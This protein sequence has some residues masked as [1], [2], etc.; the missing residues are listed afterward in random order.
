MN[1]GERGAKRLVVVLGMHRSG[2]SAAAR[3]LQ[4]LG[5]D[6]GDRLEPPD[7][8]VNAKGYFEDMDLV[9]L[10]D[11]MLAAVDRDWA[12]LVATTA[13]DVERLRRLGYIE[14][15]AALLRT[16]LRADRTF[17]CKDPRM[18]KLLDVWA[19]VFRSEALDVR[20]VFAVRN[21]LS[22]ARSIARRDGF[23][24]EAAY[25]LWLEHVVAC[26]HFLAG[27]RAVAVDFDLLLAEP[28]RQLQRLADAVGHEIDPAAADE[29]T[30]GFLA[31]D[32]RHHVATSEDVMADQAASP[33]VREATALLERLARGEC[34]IGDDFV[35]RAVAA[36]RQERGRAV[37]LQR[38]VDRSRVAALRAKEQPAE[39]LAELTAELA[40]ARKD[41]ANVAE[42]LA[43]AERRRATAE[44]A[45]AAFRRSLTWRATAPVRWSLDALLAIGGALRVAPEAVRVGGGVRATAATTLRVLW[46]EGFAGLLAR[47]RHVEL[48]QPKASTVAV[49]AR[50]LLTEP[51]R[52][53]ETRP[54]SVPVDL[55]LVHLHVEDAS[56]LAACVPT[57]AACADARCIVTLPAAAD[58]AVEACRT[59]LSAWRRIETVVAGDR[60]AVSAFVAHALP[61]LGDAQH[62]LHLRVDKGAGDAARRLAGTH[63]SGI[64]GRIARLS[65]GAP[66]ILLDCPAAAPPDVDEADVREALRQIGSDAT[67]TSF[68]ADASMDGRSIVGF[69]IRADAARALGR[70]EV[71]LRRAAGT[72]PQPAGVVDAALRAAFVPAV[73]AQ[74]RRVLRLFDGDAAADHRHH[75]AQID[76]SAQLGGDEVAVLSYYLPQFHPIPE[77]DAW[78]GVGFTEWTKVRAASPLYVGHHQQHVP[79]ADVGYYL[80]DSADVFRRQAEDMRKAGVHGQ[81]FYHYWFGGRLILEK[82]AQLLLA[83]PDVPMRF[84]FCWANENWTRRWDGNEREVLLAQAY[85]EADAVAFIR[86]L[87]PFFRDARHLTVDGR[88]LLFVYRPSSMP[89]AKAYVETWRR[90]CVAAGVAPPFVVAV[91]T[92]GAADPR[93]F[94]M[95]AAT[96]R[97]LHDWTDGACPERKHG[98]AAYAPIA[99]RV[100]AYDDVAAHYEASSPAAG[101]ETYRSIVPM[102][103]NTPRYGRD[104]YVVDGST[105][106]RFQ[107]W[108][109]RLVRQARE[110][111]PAGRRFVLV[112]AWNEWAEGAHLEAD[113]RHGHAYL[114]CIGRA[115]AGVAY[116]AADAETELPRGARV[117]ICIGDAVLAR[118]RR[119]A[120][121][122]R[123]FI[124]AIGRSSLLG[125][126]TVEL[127]DENAVTE[128]AE[129]LPSATGRFDH[130][131]QIHRPCIFGRDVLLQ[132]LLRAVRE[133][134]VMSVAN[135]Y[136]PMRLCA[137][138][139]EDDRV[140]DAALATAA[141][142]AGPADVGPDHPLRAR[143]ALAA[144]C[145]P[146][147]SAALLSSPMPEVTAII[148]FHAKGSI[149]NLR[150]ALG[151]LAAMTGCHVT[152]LL[153]L[154]DLDAETTAAV[155]S[156]VAEFD[157]GDDVSPKFVHYRSPDGRGDL[158]ARM[159][160]E[161]LRQVATRYVGFLDHDDL[162]LPHAYAWL[163]RRL[164]QT[165]KAIAFGRVY[166]TR[167]D[168]RRDLIRDRS[169]VYEA[170]TTYEHYYANNFAP[171]HSFLLDRRRLDLARV[172]Y[173]D[174]QRYME[175]Y[176]LMLQLVTR[177]NV[178]WEGLALGEYIGD[179]LHGEDGAQTL[180]I[181][182]PVERL[183]MLADPLYQT[184]QRRIDELRQSLA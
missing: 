174:D 71:A 142:V 93:D 175:D 64:A 103:D 27:E 57:L 101:F 89:N 52:A 37:P 149:A 24:A 125:A 128:L 171:L 90:E 134:R 91:L 106:R 147:A 25:E 51:M 161:S 145:F 76:W 100:L 140:A 18:A 105:P 67:G 31:E 159:L 121:F 139:D 173:F 1:G 110:R 75:E 2:T 85:S 109:E 169:R 83:S 79:H 99:G 13:D 177:G 16:K 39:D 56:A 9:A 69:W 178:D 130:V 152:P 143:L 7:A 150:N 11:E 12:S 33:A 167:Y 60:G 116:P 87:M 59:A 10:D 86:Y 28:R 184:C 180:G 98:L 162:L 133:P 158:R 36:W 118:L 160:N 129:V 126:C 82:P 92:R 117:G 55:I 38:V 5:I 62:V 63:G 3:A 21:P 54:G 146:L 48:A 32:L 72:M 61:A 137:D 114:N 136:E 4:A 65:H 22:V 155:E 166:R 49:Q 168:R 131:L 81:V 164:E 14:R 35:Q 68:V 154:Q 135:A 41:C 111:L 19:E 15:A 47:V 30:H 42:Q 151:C 58:G 26:L 179:Y 120:R 53:D 88:P 40:A 153:A 157:W 127:A 107:A 20:Y 94:G 84:C 170:G 8:A 176:Y 50:F 46:R 34:Q 43:A 29:F 78:H 138:V 132:L 115:L 97:V 73:A 23:A 156:V 74:D 45:L 163:T 17:G 113:E 95:D 77:N 148:R 165:G 80:L 102:W 104:A 144:R 6:L 181:T 70:L 182:D 108:L 141:M 172:R 66:A 122:R 123:A 183:R 119:D 124:H 112:N 96:E 44:E